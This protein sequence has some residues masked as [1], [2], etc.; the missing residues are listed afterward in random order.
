VSLRNYLVSSGID[1]SGWSKIDRA[2]SVSADGKAIVGWGTNAQGQQRGF[3]AYIPA[4]PAA[5]LL[6]VSM[7]MVRRRRN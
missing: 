6:I 7:R 2:L 5:A 3:V 4:P 1:V